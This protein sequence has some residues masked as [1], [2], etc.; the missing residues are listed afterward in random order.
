MKSFPKFFLPV[1]PKGSPEI[2]VKADAGALGLGLL[3]Q[4]QTEFRCFR[5]Q[6][7]KKPREVD[8]SG[9]VLSEN[10]V[11]VEM[12][13]AEQ[14]AH[15][16]RP[17]VINPRPARPKA[18]ISNVELMPVP[19]GAALINLRAFTLNAAPGQVPPYE[20]GDGTA[21][22]KSRQCL[23]FQPQGGGYI[24][25]IALCAGGVHHIRISSA[26]RLPVW[27]RDT[28]PHA[29][30]SYQIIHPIHPVRSFFAQ[31]PENAEYP[32]ST[33]MTTPVTKPAASGDTR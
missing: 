29:C 1:L 31:T 15:F 5:R 30:G 2:Q 8:H 6:S 14:P 28:H 12:R 9:T 10:P 19:P 25:Y 20:C 26:H 22:D 17:I 27:R 7:S 33:G 23:G 16:P 32:P 24:Q 13:C 3:R 21:L 18:G 4:D 11:K